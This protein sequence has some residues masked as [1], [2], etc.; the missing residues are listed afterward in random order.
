VGFLSGFDL[1]F[2]QAFE[3]STAIFFQMPPSNSKISLL[4]IPFERLSGL[5]LTA[6]FILAL[7]RKFKKTEE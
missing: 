5:I 3:N 4:A 7:R 6:L 1:C 2:L